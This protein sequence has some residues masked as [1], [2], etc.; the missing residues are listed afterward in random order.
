[1]RTPNAW[2]WSLDSRNP[3][4][5]DPPER[6]PEEPNPEFEISD[7]NDA[8]GSGPMHYQPSRDGI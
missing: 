4:Y 7:S 6:D 8:Q 5:E 1:M 2:R 3:D